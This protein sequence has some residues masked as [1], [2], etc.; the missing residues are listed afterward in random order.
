MNEDLR[1]LYDIKSNWRLIE[2]QRGVQVYSH[3]EYSVLLRVIDFNNKMIHFTDRKRI[4][5]GKVLDINKPLTI[6][7]RGRLIIPIIKVMDAEK[8][9]VMP[10]VPEKLKV[11]IEDFLDIFAILYYMDSDEEKSIIPVKRYFKRK[12]SSYEEISFEEYNKMKEEKESVDQAQQS[13]V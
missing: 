4:E 13:T 9:I 6:M 5:P 1:P 7:D 3:T 8:P 11:Y 12:N 10:Y 2:E